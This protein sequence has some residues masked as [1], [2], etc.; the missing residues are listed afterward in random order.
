MPRLD[1]TGMGFHI[2]M[3][4]SFLYSAILFAGC[5]FDNTILLSAA[6]E[7]DAFLEIT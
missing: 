7:K 4:R 3:V 2:G 1:M 6:N 5:L